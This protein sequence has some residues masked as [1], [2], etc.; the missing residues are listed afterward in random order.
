MVECESVPLAPV[1]VTVNTPVVEPV[2]DSV[3][4][5]EVVVLV[6]ET[7]VG[8][9]VQVRPVA[10]AIV[11]DSVTVPVKLFTAATVIVEVPADPRI[12]ETVAGL[13][14]IV[15]SG[16][17]V[18][19]KVTV[20][21]CES[22]P[23]APVTVIVKLPVADPLQDRVEVPEPATLVGLRVQVRPVEGEIVS[24]NA[25]A[26]VKPFVPVTVI[27]DVPGEPTAV[28]T[29]VGAATRVKSGAGVAV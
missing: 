11:S 6:R 25:T 20:A 28:L 26:P 14:L 29:F 15:K 13:A 21:V 2:H 23:L 8:L 24:V 27:V 3:E 18:T 5:A 16:A 17:A 7:L 4:E 9:S 12:I 10:G 19:V 1:T 22:V